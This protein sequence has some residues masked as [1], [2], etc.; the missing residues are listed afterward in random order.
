M[1]RQYTAPAIESEEV[2]EQTSLACNVSNLSDQLPQ[3]AS[4]FRKSEAFFNDE[5]L[6]CQTV[7]EQAACMAVLS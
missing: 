1:R 5:V 6:E 3:C 4:Q 2:L 7:L